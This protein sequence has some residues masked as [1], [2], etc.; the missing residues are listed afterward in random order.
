MDVEKKTLFNL[1]SKSTTHY[2]TIPINTITTINTTINT[3]NTITTINT[4]AYSTK[5]TFFFPLPS[6]GPVPVSPHFSFPTT[7]SK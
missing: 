3:I 2:F 1:N 4:T 5:L 7:T 6:T